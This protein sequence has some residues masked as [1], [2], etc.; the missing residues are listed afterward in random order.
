MIRYPISFKTQKNT[1]VRKKRIDHEGLIQM[2]I[3]K[4]LRVYEKDNL[5]TFLHIPNE[6]SVKL[7][8]LV[9]LKRW[10]MGVQPGVWDLL[11]IYHNLPSKLQSMYRPEDD[12]WMVDLI[13]HSNVQYLWIELKYDA[14]KLKKVDPEKKL[15]KAQKEFRDKID[16]F[17]AKH[18]IICVK[19]PIEGIEKL[20]EI[21]QIYKVI[22]L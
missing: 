16:F 6:H 18:E 1:K 11:I 2:E 15:T 5:L 21:L 10:K 20:E 12:K 7:P 22:C 8:K 4:R 3:V 13:G 17:D 9:Q 19:N 14:N